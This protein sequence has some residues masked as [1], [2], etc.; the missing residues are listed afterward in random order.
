MGTQCR[1]VVLFHALMLVDLFV[2]YTETRKWIIVLNFEGDVG[3]I[4]NVDSE[5]FSRVFMCKYACQAFK[6]PRDTPLEFK[7]KDRILR[8]DSDVAGIFDEN[9]ESDEINIEVSLPDIE[10]LATLPADGA[11]G[12]NFIPRTDLKKAKGSRG[13][14]RKNV[15]K[16]VE[17]ERNAT[18]EGCTTEEAFEYVS[19]EEFEWSGDEEDPYYNENGEDDGEDDEEG[20]ENEESDKNEAGSDGL[21][22]GDAEMFDE[23]IFESSEDGLSDY[24]FEGS[25]KSV[26]SESED[27]LGFKKRKRNTDPLRGIKGSTYKPK[28]GEKVVF[29]EDQLFVNV[30]SFRDILRDYGVDGGYELTE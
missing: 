14:P 12:Y 30:Q 3:H 7:M 16:A 4:D 17:N 15:D 11:F 6:L 2:F 8:S 29:K 20:D 18:E 19:D 1:K 24:M 23:V 9:V 22:E 26:E 27:E 10:P 25:L 13:R 28:E 21:E 5:L